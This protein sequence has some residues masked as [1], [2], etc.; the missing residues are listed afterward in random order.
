[1]IKTFNW[2]DKEQTARAWVNI[3]MNGYS[4][5]ASD[6]ADFIYLT[7][8]NDDQVEEQLNKGMFN[9]YLVT[10]VMSPLKELYKD[11]CLTS[12]VGLC[13]PKELTY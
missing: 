11:Y 13:T 2:E 6:Y 4:F 7:G 12:T 8:F 10:M 5:N 9:G 1:M 3:Y